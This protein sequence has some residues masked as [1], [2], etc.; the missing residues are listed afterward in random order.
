MDV[1]KDIV[2]IAVLAVLVIKV[3]AQEVNRVIRKNR[4]NADDIGL[5]C[6]FIQMSAN[7]RLVK[8]NKLPEWTVLTLVFMLYTPIQPPILAYRLIS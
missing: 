5:L 6:I 7:D 8:R 3:G 4:I 2:L 1:R